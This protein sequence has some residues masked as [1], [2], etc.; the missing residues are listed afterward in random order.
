MQIRN[1]NAQTAVEYLLLLAIVVGIILVALPTQL[2]RVYQ[3]ANL[4]FNKAANALFGR[5]SDCGDGVCDATIFEDN[6]RC[7]DDCG[8][9]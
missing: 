5:A 3:S 1:K 7:C 9:C 2:P 4:Y 6:N 8:G